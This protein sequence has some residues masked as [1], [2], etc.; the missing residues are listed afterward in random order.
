M[1]LLFTNI[2][3]LTP[4]LTEK[5][6]KCLGGKKNNVI[7]WEN[8]DKNKYINIIQKYFFKITKTRFFTKLEY[9]GPTG[10]SS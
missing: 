8:W 3:T 2:L 5:Y 9:Q 4:N 1:I 10:P 6:E 7:E